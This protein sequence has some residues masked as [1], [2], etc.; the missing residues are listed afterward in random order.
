MEKVYL[1][2]GLGNP[3]SEYGSTRHNAGFMLLEHLA[4]RWKC[5]WAMQRKFQAQVARAELQDHRLILCQPQ[6]F[7]NASGEAVKPLASY[8][9]V[10]LE[11]TLITVDDADLPLGEIRLRPAGS[12]GGHHGL[13]SIENQ[14]GSRDYPRLRLGIGRRDNAD[15]QIT[16]YVLGRFTAREREQLALVLE[17]AADQIECWIQSGIQKAMSLYNGMVCVE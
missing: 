6:T 10:A 1:I 3:G 12:S 16:G 4:R 9:K 5:D 8:Y 15:R 14:L 17:R 7:M 11:H 2:V 13:E